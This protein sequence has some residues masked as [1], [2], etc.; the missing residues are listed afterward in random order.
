M[1]NPVNAAHTPGQEPAHLTLRPTTPADRPVLERLGQLFRHDM[2]EVSGAL[3]DPSGQ[4]RS[5]R[6]D[7]LFTDPGRRGLIAHLEPADGTPASPVGF[8]LVRDVDERTR[9][10]TAF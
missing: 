9:V 5:E 7:A 10:L 1:T 4:F 6:L 3:P 8:S 2:S